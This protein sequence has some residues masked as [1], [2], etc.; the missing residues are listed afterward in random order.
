LAARCAWRCLAFRRRAAAATT[1]TRSAAT[2]T[3]GTGGRSGAVT[4]DF[5]S[6]IAIHCNNTGRCARIED[7]VD[8]DRSLLCADTGERPSLCELPN[9]GRVDLF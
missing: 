6:S 2:T 4:P 5:L 1:T 7:S 8:S 3:T 9:I